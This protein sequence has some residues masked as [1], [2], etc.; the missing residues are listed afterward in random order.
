MSIIL[1]LR[2]CCCLQASFFSHNSRST[3]SRQ[4]NSRIGALC[5]ASPDLK[6]VKADLIA[7]P[8]KV[9]TSRG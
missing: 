4:L 3:L 5:A 7:A 9:R 1:L 6:I 8:R 2:D